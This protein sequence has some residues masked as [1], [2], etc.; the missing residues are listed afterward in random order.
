MFSK[1]KNFIHAFKAVNRSIKATKRLLEDPEMQEISG[2]RHVVMVAQRTKDNPNIAIA[3]HFTA[4][5]EHPTLEVMLDLRREIMEDEDLRNNCGWNPALD[6]S[7]LI[8]IA[9]GNYSEPFIFG[10]MGP[11][12]DNEEESK[13]S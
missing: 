3:R 6:Y 12:A 1:I 2:F 9:M 11:A 4:F 13:E 10:L 8:M 5:S 7:N